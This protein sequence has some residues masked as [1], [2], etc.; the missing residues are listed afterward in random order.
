M[1]KYAFPLHE[2]GIHLL[3]TSQFM[4]IKK[5]A[6]TFSISGTWEMFLKKLLVVGIKCCLKMKQFS[7]FFDFEDKTSMTK[8]LELIGNENLMAWNVA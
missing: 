8:T 7:N 2:N 4:E 1:N 6:L 5:S 3:N